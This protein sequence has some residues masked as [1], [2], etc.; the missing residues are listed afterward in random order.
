MTDELAP[1]DE[2]SI[3]ETIAEEWSKIS[4]GMSDDVA[5]EPSETESEK[6]DRLRDEQGRFAAKAETPDEPATEVLADE[7]APAKKDMPI[8]W[9]REVAAEWDKL[10]DRVKDEVLK[11]E[12]D[13]RK[14]FESYKA[15]ADT[16]KAFKSAVQPYMA[17]IQSFGATPEQAAQMLFSADHQMR[18][19]N[20]QQKMEMFRSMAQA[21]GIDL[22][23]LAPQQN[24]G[25]AAQQAPDID[26]IVR[27]HL[28]R[29]E[30]ERQARES[31]YYAQAQEQQ[32]LTAIADF[33]YEREPNGSLKIRGYDDMGNPVYQLKA[34]REEFER[35]STLMG[36]LMQANPSLDLE[37]A[38]SDALY[39]HPETRQVLIA[40][41]QG[42]HREDA[43]KKAEQA[44]RAG[45]VNIRTRGALPAGA[46]GGSMVDTITSEAQ[47]LGLAS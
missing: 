15:D 32:S 23:N 12:A 45:A 2:K 46:A 22:G 37:K 6:A 30:A 18:Y 28:S 33:A 36:A 44:K 17:T 27:Q 26:G 9:R 4:A 38:Y 24:A 25:E 11:R 35:V 14:G 19:G 42:Q 31:Q 10:P 39:A 47:R 1:Q 16:G 29:E 5:D 7:S 20:P 40:Q 3:D 21:Y 8:S 34:G 43:R 13:V 41:Q